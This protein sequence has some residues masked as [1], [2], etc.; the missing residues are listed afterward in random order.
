[1]ASPFGTRHGDANAAST[2]RNATMEQRRSK[3]LF[4][5][6]QSQKI[7]LEKS[8]SLTNSCVAAFKRLNFLA[9]AN[10]TTRLAYRM[11]PERISACRL[12][13]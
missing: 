10:A 7:V 6:R 11:L 4:A 3:T 12:Q 1:M 13:G 5:P 9:T 2:L 8:F